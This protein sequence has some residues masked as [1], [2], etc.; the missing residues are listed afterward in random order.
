M[1]GAAGER[2]L[3]GGRPGEYGYWE[4][5]E[6]RLPPLPIWELRQVIATHQPDEMGARKAA[7]ERLYRIGG[8]AGGEPRFDVADPHAAGGSR[9]RPG[10]LPPPRQGGPARQPPPP[11]FRG[12][13]PPK[14]LLIE[15]P[16]RP[17]AAI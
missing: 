3:R 17:P 15:G 13:P 11:G 12:Q 8:E 2:F 7:A 9:G 10:P 6:N 4:G 5:A 16:P 14:P 1:R